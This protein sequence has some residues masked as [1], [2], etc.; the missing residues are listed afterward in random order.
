MMAGA[1]RRR[2]SFSGQI[3]AEMTTSLPWQLRTPAQLGQLFEAFATAAHEGPFDLDYPV[4]KAGPSP[5]AHGA[6][7]TG[8]SWWSA[9]ADVT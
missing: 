9:I 5:Y 4:R 1:L 8:L 7:H 2:H 3:A 6:G